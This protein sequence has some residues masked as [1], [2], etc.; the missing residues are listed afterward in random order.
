M[1]VK[2]DNMANP[3]MTK[4]KKY[5][6]RVDRDGSDGIN[7]QELGCL[8]EDLRMTKTEAQ[9]QT[10]INE[11]DADGSGEISFGEFCILLKV[12]P[13]TD[14]DKLVLR[15]TIAIALIFVF[16]LSFVGLAPQLN[17]GWGN[18]LYFSIITFTTVGLGDYAPHFKGSGS[19]LGRMLLMFVLSV[20]LVIG[21]AL[22]T[23]IIGAL[24]QFFGKNISINSLPN[25]PELDARGKRISIVENPMSTNA[26]HAT[27]SSDASQSHTLSELTAESGETEAEIQNEREKRRSNRNDEMRQRKSLSKKKSRKKLIKANYGLSEVTCTTNAI[28]SA[29]EKVIEKGGTNEPKRNSG[30]QRKDKLEEN[31]MGKKTTSR[32]GTQH[33]EM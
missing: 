28:F 12:K 3:E 30:Q 14:N 29:E 11:A 20:L 33:Y 8:M 4:L 32:Q 24:R 7:A 9:I 5:F 26:I 21:L 18:S 16:C 10:M 15:T 25:S 27:H 31:P 6:D 13:P 2:I 17:W 22:F 19:T 1:G 23:S